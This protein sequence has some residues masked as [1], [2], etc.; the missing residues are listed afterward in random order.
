MRYTYG[1]QIIADFNKDI[2]ERKYMHRVKGKQICTQLF[3]PV[4]KLNDT[5]EIGKQHF[6]TISTNREFQPELFL[7][8]YCSTEANPKF[9]DEEGCTKLGKLRWFS[10]NHQKKKEGPTNQVCYTHIGCFSN[11][12]P[13]W[14]TFGTLPLSPEHIA[15]TFH[16]YTRANPTNGQLLDPNGTGASVKSTHFNGAHRTVFIIHG[17][18]GEEDNN[19]IKLMTSA[20]VKNFN[21]NVIVVVWTKGAYDKYN[22]AVANTRV[23]GAITANMVKLLHTSGGLTLNHVHLVGHSLGAH[24]AGYVGENIPGIGRITGLDPA[25]PEF[26]RANQDVR[27]DSSDATFVDVIHSDA[28]IAPFYSCGHMRAVYYFIESVNSDCHFTSHPCNSGDDYKNGHCA[29]CGKGCQEMGYNLSLYARGT[30]YLRTNW[31]YPYCA[32]SH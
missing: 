23:V 28:T 25:G 30:Y 1:I 10:Q 26:N 9:T 31:H 5:V 14:N 13:F 27:L 21:V 6:S 17:F 3:E 24:I 8:I 32:G 20:L 12:A 2:H 19:W 7:P 16:L 18:H 4:V 11:S 15:T 22:Q 29:H